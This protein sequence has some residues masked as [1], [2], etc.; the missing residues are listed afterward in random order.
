MFDLIAIGDPVID[1]HVQ[2][3]DENNDLVSLVGSDKLC[4]DYGD[5]IPIID[6]FQ[7]LGGN[8]PNVGVAAA[9]LGMKTALLS[10]VG[11]DV[12]GVFALNELSR[13]NVDLNMVYIDKKSKTLK[14]VLD[15]VKRL[16]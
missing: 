10:T 5:K 6:S 3:S 7:S 16:W 13:H 11:N 4:F 8:A 2:I 12:N 1:T 15:N 9:K 14:K